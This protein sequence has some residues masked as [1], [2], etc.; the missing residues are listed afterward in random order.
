MATLVAKNI[1]GKFTA[2]GEA[3]RL[4]STQDRSTFGFAS[5][6]KLK[7]MVRNS[8]SYKEWPDNVYLNDP[9]KFG[10]SF[11][12]YG[13]PQGTTRLRPVSSEVLYTT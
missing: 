4:I 13:M 3:V 6:D 5:D 9:T 12:Q 11:Q 8:W 2:S 7:E 1:N 10:N